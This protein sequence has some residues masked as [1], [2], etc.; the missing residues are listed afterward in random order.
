MDFKKLG[1]KLAGEGL[2]LIATAF[3]GPAAGS[4]AKMVTNAL[5]LSE[6]AS[7]DEIIQHMESNPDAVIKLKELQLNHEAELKRL[8]IKE[9]EMYL[10]DT[11]DAR[12]AQIER[13]KQTGKT[14]INL[15]VLAWVNVIGFF[16]V[17]IVLMFADI[18]GEANNILYMLLGVLAT[19]FAK[20]N[21]YFFG[22]SQ[23]S[24]DKTAMLA[25]G[26]KA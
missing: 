12:K 3:G 9:S 19:C 7:E 17:V 6:D 8:G 26:K 14:D 11:Q 20:V 16:A 25:V 23:G 18:E 1:K 5:G 22:S 21:S 15:Y 24:K 4:V 2:P 13:E 10:I